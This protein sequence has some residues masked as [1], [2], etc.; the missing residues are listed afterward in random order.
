MHD[1]SSKSQR[2]GNGLKDNLVTNRV[3]AKTIF[4]KTRFPINRG[5]HRMIKQRA[6]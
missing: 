3:N 2:G 1:E 5:I 6:V 4:L